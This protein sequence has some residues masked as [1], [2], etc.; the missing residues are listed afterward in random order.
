[1]PENK[2]TFWQKIKWLASY[3]FIDGMGGMA[4][5]LFSTLIAGTIIWQTGRLIN[6]QGNAYNFFGILLEAVGKIAQIAMGAGVGVGIC[7]KLKKTSPLIVASSAAAAMIGSYAKNIIELVIAGAAPGTNLVFA[8]NGAGDPMGAFIGG[9]AAMAIGNLVSGKTKLDI[10]VTP[11]AA[12]LVGGIVGIALGYPISLALTALGNL[13]SYVENFPPIVVALTGLII[14]VIMGFCLT[15]PVS[16]AAIG[17]AVGLSGVAAGA[18]VVGCCCHMVG[19]AVMSFR[20]NKWDGLL[21][22]GLGT[23]M[24][25][26]P[27]VFK[28]PVLLVPP[29]ISSAL[30][31]ALAV[32]VP[33]GNGGFGL[34]ATKVGSGMGTAGLVGVIDMIFAMI[35]P[36]VNANGWL[37]ALWVALFCFVL[38]AAITLGI[39]E[40]FRKL[41]IIKPGDLALKLK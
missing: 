38:P 37:T 17:I 16:S 32:L 4:L 21:A 20:E 14:A 6:G 15:M 2:K 23:S 30:L 33:I 25:Q 24:L 5:G 12:I 35:D 39:S 11:L 13:I 3:I 34:A 9:I 7:I 10:L 29:I 22:Q 19:F 36:K 1:M 31:G 26:I 8:I 41:N 40:L 27:N 18:A 28:K